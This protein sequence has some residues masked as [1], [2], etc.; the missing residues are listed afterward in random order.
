MARK[1]QLA[2]KNIT[3][4]AKRLATLLRAATNVGSSVSKAK[5]H[6]F[7][8]YEHE[9]TVE[10]SPTRGD[11]VVANSTPAWAALAHPG[12]GYAL[13]PDANDITWDQ[14][15]TWTGLHTWGNV[16]PPAI[17][18]SMASGDPL[19]QL[20]RVGQTTFALGLDDDDNDIFKINSAATLADPSDFELD[21]SGNVEIGGDFNLLTGKGIIHADG[22]TAGYILR[23]DGTR[24]IPANPATTLPIAPAAQGD[25]IVAD[26]TPAWSILTLA[27]GAGY[28]LVSTATTVTWDQTPTWTGTHYFGASVG[29]GLEITIASGDP[30]MRWDIGGTDKFCAGVDDDDSDKF[31]IHGASSLAASSDF[32]LDSSGNVEIGGDFNFRTGKG[33]THADGVTAGWVLVSDGTR[34]VPSA[35]GGMPTPSGQ[36]YIL[37]SDA[38]PAFVEYLANTNGAILIGDGTDITSDTTPT[39]AGLTTFSGGWV[40]TNGG[41]TGDLDGNDLIIDQDGDSYLHASGDD[42][43]DLVLAGAS[44]EFGI[45][46]NGAEDITVT[47]NSLNVLSGS[48]IDCNSVLEIRS[49]GDIQSTGA[50]LHSATQGGWSADSNLAMLID[51]D[52]SGTSDWFS[53]YHDGVDLDA[54]S[55]LFRV[56]EAPKVFVNDNANSKMG[57]GLTINQGTNTDEALAIKNSTV[58]HGMTNE[59]ET[60]TYW[61]V[62]PVTATGGGGLVVGLSEVEVGL[63]LAGYA[64]TADTTK[65]TGSLAAVEIVAAKKSG[66]GIGTMGTDGNL[67]AIVDDTST[68]FIFDADGSAYANVEWETFDRYDDAALLTALEAEYTRRDVIGSTFGQWAREHRDTLRR[69]RIIGAGGMLNTTRLLMLHTG[70]IRQVG[71]EAR[72]G[73]VD[74]QQLRTEVQELKQQM[75][76][77]SAGMM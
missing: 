37:R 68:E 71:E 26:A 67:L 23:A 56:T 27:G 34:Y 58:A 51:S 75:R 62:Q 31:K 28:A 45:H 64:T 5:R 57:I 43:V 8:S 14:T 70:A 30:I 73:K 40:V 65:N 42:V 55:L 22:V 13:I 10:Q 69:E 63:R 77:L 76:A 41:G 52:N 7:L 20:I 36:G 59:A 12:A 33:I 74:R 3:A 32:E 47:A 35:T 46:I 38:T 1:D 66:T 4:D 44:G 53:V 17:R 72:R 15:P 25:L 49:H 9:D 29:A 48:V 21:T 60:D 11:I 39:I 16:G 18:I 54:A 6:D 61:L 24:Y 2:R 50:D 19:M